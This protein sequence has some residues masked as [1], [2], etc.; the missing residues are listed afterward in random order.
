[1]LWSIPI[2][3]SPRHAECASEQIGRRMNENTGAP[4][5]PAAPP[6]VSQIECVWFE[7]LVRDGLRQHCVEVGSTAEEQT[8]CRLSLQLIKPS[9]AI[10]S[11]V[12]T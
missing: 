8:P 6:A 2:L 7:R 3:L 4:R 5:Q 1:M 11:V 12:Q 10:V 9:G